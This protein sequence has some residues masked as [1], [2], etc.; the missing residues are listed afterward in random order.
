M[1]CSLDTFAAIHAPRLEVPRATL[2]RAL[3]GD[4]YWRPKTK[5]IVGG[6]KA[7]K[8]AEPLFVSLVLSSIWK[9]YDAISVNHNPER[10]AKIVSSLNLTVD[11]REL[12]QVW[13]VLPL[14]VRDSRVP[15]NA[16]WSSRR[17]CVFFFPLCGVTVPLSLPVVSVT[18]TVLSLWYSCHC[19]RLMPEPDDRRCSGRGCPSARRC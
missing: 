14:L 1:P 15:D 5:S 12:A 7:P 8:G 6:D 2:R 17:R 13:H 10:V 4:Y 18:V 11:A 9:V 19:C 16:L 3:W